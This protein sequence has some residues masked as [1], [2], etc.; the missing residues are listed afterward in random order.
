MEYIKNSILDLFEYSGV[1]NHDKI[2]DNILLGNYKST[3]RDN[4]KNSGIDVVINCSP[5]LP[6]NNKLL[7]NYRIAVNDDLTNKANLD[8]F[9]NIINILPI[10]HNHVK[11]NHKILIHCK[12]GMQR[13]A[14]VTAA[15][16]MKYHDLSIEEAKKFIQE[17]RPI[18][19]FMGSNF[20]LCLLLF[21]K[22]LKTLI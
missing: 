7:H 13:S 8:L 1:N 18:A 12:A 14:A 4:I 2:T 22:H 21:Q 5:N 11:Q 20:N 17:K 15:Y 16:L 10:I 6:F 3:S 9:E 19:F